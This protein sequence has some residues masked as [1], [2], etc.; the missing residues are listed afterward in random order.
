MDFLG[1]YCLRL[2][3]DPD[4]AVTWV[5]DPY[6]PVVAQRF[7]PDDATQQWNMEADQGLFHFRSRV[8]VDP[9]MYLC[10]DGNDRPLNTTQVPYVPSTTWDISD[11]EAPFGRIV[12]TF[13]SQGMAL[14]PK[15]L[16]PDPLVG[17]GVK[18]RWYLQ[19]V[20]RRSI[21]SLSTL[22]RNQFKNAMFSILTDSKVAQFPAGGRT[23]LSNAKAY[24]RAIDIVL[25]V[26]LGYGVPRWFPG[27]PIPP[28][29][30]YVR[31]HDNGTQRSPLVNS[32]PRLIPSV[33]LTY[34]LLSRFTPDALE[35]AIEDWD[36]R[37]RAAVG[38]S[39]SDPQQAAAAPIFWCWY[40][41]L[42]QMFS[43]YN[44]SYPNRPDKDAPA[45]KM[46]CGA[47][48][49]GRLQLFINGKSGALTSISE[50]FG[51]LS[52]P[53]QAPPHTRPWTAWQR[54]P[55]SADAAVARNADGRL[56][57][58]GMNG[59]NV[60][61]SSQQGRG[62]GFWT[63]PVSTGT[64]IMVGFGISPAADK[65]LEMFGTNGNGLL[66]NSQ[67]GPGGP[68]NGWGYVGG[69]GIKKSSVAVGLV[70][71][72]TVVALHIGSDDRIW[73]LTQF[74]DGTC[75]NP[76]AISPPGMKIDKVACIQDQSTRLYG[77]AITSDRLLMTSLN[78]PK[79][80]WPSWSRFDDNVIEMSVVR[81]SGGLLEL[82]M[83][84]SDGTVTR[85]WQKA[86]EI[87]ALVAAMPVQGATHIAAG[88][89]SKKRVQLFVTQGADQISYSMQQTP[90]DPQSYA[91]FLRFY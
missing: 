61:G 44:A 39:L 7:R 74:P 21:N 35:A 80:V 48:A 90:G 12:C 76:Y 53:L 79:N 54:I 85:T 59:S 38:G 33:D 83:L 77:F 4:L 46:F 67:N 13:Y 86:G 17:L 58:C 1:T 2:A 62:L 89:D 5:S 41:W 78:S 18:T 36:S 16:G 6:T 57:V 87:W 28:E 37:V 64:D 73:L 51:G 88:L 31:P 75:G 23:I 84:H 69:S 71:D 30:M 52:G 60:V 68:W 82:F 72:G 15:H 40:A 8:P 20:P 43:D 24:L 34:P 42:A 32:D 14:S 3:D 65:R 91:P 9:P 27:D 26:Q 45:A 70:G 66:N 47:N 56:Q 19:R 11:G 81:N 55:N 63:A 10:G 50:D 22:E 25:G 49:D 29:L